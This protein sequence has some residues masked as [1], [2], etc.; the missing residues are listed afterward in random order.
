[1][2]DYVSIPDAQINQDRPVTKSLMR[3]LRDNLLAVISGALGAPRIQ[4]EAIGGFTAGNILLHT[5]AAAVGMTNADSTGMQEWKATR[6]QHD[7]TYRVKFTFSVN[8]GYGATCQLYVDDVAI[9][10][11]TTAN[12]NTV[13]ISNDV[14]V[15]WGQR[16][17][18][19]GNGGGAP[20]SSGATV[21]NLRI[22]AN[23]PVSFGTIS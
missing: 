21:S 4:P 11:P 6:V 23:K 13:E 1:M 19:R 3:A 18:I 7:G 17:N 15:Q 8:A 22:Y 16:V 20:G 2:V 14:T 12:G 5:N 9:G 10:T